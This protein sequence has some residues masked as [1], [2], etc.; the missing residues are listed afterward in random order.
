MFGQHQEYIL[1]HT[2]TH[3]H[4]YIIYDMIFI[5]QRI[6][7]LNKQVVTYYPRDTSFY[8]SS[9]YV[10]YIWNSHHCNNISIYYNHFFL[11][12]SI[13]LVSMC[14]VILLVILVI[15]VA[16]VHGLCFSSC[17]FVKKLNVIKQH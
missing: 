1:P 10:L 3:T 5:I 8:G 17:K 12:C 7:I 6:N 4:I 13:V 9:S 16:I 11:S 14:M 2:H 15:I